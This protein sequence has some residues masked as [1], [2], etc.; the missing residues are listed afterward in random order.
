MS[1]AGIWL[2]CRKQLLLCGVC[3]CSAIWNT[4]RLYATGKMVELPYYTVHIKGLWKYYNDDFCVRYC[5]KCT[6]K[7]ILKFTKREFVMA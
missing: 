6:E 2:D 4:I 7:G 5:R 3:I 1:K